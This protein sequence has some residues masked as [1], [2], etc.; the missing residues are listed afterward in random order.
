MTQ[1]RTFN[2]TTAPRLDRRIGNYWISP[3]SLIIDRG[4]GRGRLQCEC[5]ERR[6]SYA[7]AVV[8]FV[9][10]EMPQ[11][12]Q[13][14]V[15]IL[16]LRTLLQVEN[17]SAGAND[18][19][20]TRRDTRSVRRRVVV[21]IA[22]AVSRQLSVDN[23]DRELFC[24]GQ[25]SFTCQNVVASTVSGLACAVQCAAVRETRIWGASPLNRSW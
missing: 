7:P 25:N 14:G 4:D 19:T 2:H 24:D 9:Q 16:G 15:V 22:T 12:G 17:G 11:W 21:G 3:F 5:H 18:R 1:K 6:E 23:S 20:W 8:A 10:L 13:V